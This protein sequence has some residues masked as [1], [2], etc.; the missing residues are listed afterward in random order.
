MIGVEFGRRVHEIHA[1]G[2]P[3]AYKEIGQR[4]H[5]EVAEDFRQRIDLVLLSDRPDFQKGKTGVHGQDHDRADQNKQGIGAMDQAVHSALQIFH[6]L[7]DLMVRKST[8]AV[9]V[10]CPCTK[11]QLRR[12][13]SP[14]G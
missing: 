2:N 14:I 3:I 12:N 9:R 13:S 6:G 1:I 5:G 11:L 7:A 8:K 4:R 10:G